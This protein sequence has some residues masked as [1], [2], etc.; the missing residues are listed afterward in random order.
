MSLQGRKFVE[1][2]DLAHHWFFS[3]LSESLQVIL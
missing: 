1:K 3:A 2:N